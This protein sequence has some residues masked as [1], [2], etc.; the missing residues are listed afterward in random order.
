MNRLNIQ[1]DCLAGVLS[2]RMLPLCLL[3]F[4]VLLGA[5]SDMKDDIGPLPEPQPVAVGQTYFR[6]HISLAEP[7]APTTRAEETGES[8]GSDHENAI[9]SF[10][11]FIFDGNYGYVTDINLTGKVENNTEYLYSTDNLVLKSGTHYMVAFANLPEAL[12]D[13]VKNL[14]SDPEHFLY[15]PVNV[16]SGP[17]VMGM[18]RFYDVI[19]YFARD[20][21]GRQSLLEEAPDGCI[22]MQGIGKNNSGSS[23]FDLSEVHSKDNPLDV[24]FELTRSVAKV[25]LLYTDTETSGGVDFLKTY[26][27]A[28]ET[29]VT[30][31]NGGI[32]FIRADSVYYTVNSLNRKI[33]LI[34]KEAEPSKYSKLWYEDPNMDLTSVMQKVDAKTYR[35]DQSELDAEFVYTPPQDYSKLTNAQFYQHFERAEKLDDAKLKRTNSRQ[36]GGYVKGVYA[37]P[38]G[39]AKPTPDQTDGN[40]LLANNRINPVRSIT[41]LQ[42]AAR[43]MPRELYVDRATWTSVTDGKNTDLTDEERKFVEELFR[44]ATKQDGYYNEDVFMSDRGVRLPVN[45]AKTNFELDCVHIDFG[46]RFQVAGETTVVPNTTDTEVDLYRKIERFLALCLKVQG[47]YRNSGTEWQANFFTPGTYWTVPLPYTDPVTGKQETKYY[48]ITERMARTPGTL[49]GVRNKIVPHVGGWC[50]FFSYIED[51]NVKNSEDITHYSDPNMGYVNSQL[52][53]NT[54]YLPQLHRITVPGNGDDGGTYIE[55]NTFSI[56]WV[57]AGEGKTFLD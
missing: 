10:Y 36:G 38:N 28:D 42:V 8:V 14:A 31:I 23:S 45:G 57:D 39:Y 5:C 15:I 1:T 12:Y 40:N 34:P 27:K 13:K 6:F 47:A 20:S 30:N 25:H 11:V 53:R 54:Y 22:Q 24:R 43:L 3:L 26:K 37:L 9:R 21:Y 55:V 2:R 56:P 46:Q 19:N 29:G 35:Y 4:A 32:G 17:S 18:S 16:G 51:Y 44:G 52:L 50:Y 41:H 33:Y 48:F 7:G 49:T